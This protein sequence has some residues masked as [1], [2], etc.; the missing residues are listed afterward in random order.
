MAWGDARD[1][2]GWLT[3]QL[4]LASAVPLVAAATAS[5][6]GHQGLNVALPQQRDSDGAA[7]SA[8]LPSAQAVL[9]DARKA[10]EHW[11]STIPVENCA[12]T[13]ATFV[14]G[15]MEYYKSTVSS[16]TP[17][18]V[19]LNY[20]RRW[21]DEWQYQI[22]VGWRE[23]SGCVALP[24]DTAYSTGL[25]WNVSGVRSVEACCALADSQQRAGCWGFT[26]RPD[27][28]GSESGVCSLHTNDISTRHE[29]G[30][31]SG[32]VRQGYGFPPPPSPPWHGKPKPEGTLDNPHN[33]N[34]QLCG[35]VYAEL[36]KLGGMQNKTLL[37]STEAVLG[38][39]M[40]DP[41]N[42]RSLWSWVDAL[43]MGM[44]TY[45]RMGNLT[46]DS[47]Y[48]D[49]QWRMFNYSALAVRTATQLAAKRGTVYF[50]QLQF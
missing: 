10:A 45:S 9:A 38:A 3:L 16:G 35:A 36:Y 6:Y 2:V 41:A 49:Q 28:H 14:I 33:A 24:P 31:I 48:Y 40:A 25:M 47:R 1:L 32:W 21:A 37:A 19:A 8:G 7:A 34:E 26:Y 30:A 18:A 39:E 42:S 11:A 17:D 23:E 44:S 4:L 27:I 46:G 20:A 22:C 50:V 12:W 15:L 29:T 13:G 43:H 5:D